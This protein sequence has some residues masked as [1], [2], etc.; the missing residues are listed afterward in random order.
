MSVTAL[1]SIFVVDVV[2]RKTSPQKR[3]FVVRHP[4]DVHIAASG[5]GVGG[6]QTD[7]L[8]QLAGDGVVLGLTGNDDPSVG[9]VDIDGAD[10]IELHDVAT[11]LRFLDVLERGNDG[12]LEG[13]STKGHVFYAR[14]MA[15]AL[16]TPRPVRLGTRPARRP[17]SVHVDSPAGPTDD[18]FN[19]VV[20]AATSMFGDPTRR[21]IYLLVRESAD[22]VTSAETAAL[23]D[24]HPNVARHHL[25]KLVGGGYLDVVSA[26]GPGERRSGRPSKRYRVSGK[27]IDL[28]FG[29][30]KHDL[31]VSLLSKALDLLPFD[32]AS[33][34]AEDV[35]EHYGRE[36]AAQMHPGDSHRSMRSA[37]HAVADALTAHGFAAHTEAREEGLAIVAGHCP[38]GELSA[39]HPVI[40][41]VDRGMVR[42]MLS[43]LYGDAAPL[44]AASRAQG[45]ES[46]VTTV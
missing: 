8:R 23:V 24:L 25:D 30:R 45:D 40:C 28:E 14:R 42:G 36:L 44:L 22:G 43:S 31:V 26:A 32:V 12:G 1:T 37:L 33:K 3:P 5:T 34:M 46:C 17:A 27:P 15:N 13:R 41:A 7:G 16:V 39:T 11:D 21:R 6:G 38:F 10:H 19:S 29:A 18:E 35:G 20:T 2:G 9:P 4:G